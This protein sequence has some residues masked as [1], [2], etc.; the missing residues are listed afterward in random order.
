VGKAA[1]RCGLEAEQYKQ[2]LTEQNGV[3]AI[4]RQK[5]NGDR[6]L[7]VDHCHQSGRIRG[8]LCAA[9]NLSLG[10]MQDDPDALR[11]AADYAEIKGTSAHAWYDKNDAANGW[12][13]EERSEWPA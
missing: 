12:P 5:P 4:C 7:A 8:L 6:N 10:A 11:R 1:V 2:L 13:T 9:C 3:C